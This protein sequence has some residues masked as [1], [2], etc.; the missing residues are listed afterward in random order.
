M[1]LNKKEYYK[2]YPS[3]FQMNNKVATGSLL[4]LQPNESQTSKQISDF[5]I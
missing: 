2:V 3:V 1:V 5:E 4:D